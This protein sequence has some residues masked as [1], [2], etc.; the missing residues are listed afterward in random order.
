MP[1]D[2]TTILGKR[3]YR[4]RAAAGYGGERKAAEFARRLGITP[5]SLHDLESGKSRQLG[6][7]AW[8]GY[9]SVGANPHYII[10]GNGLPMLKNIEK[11]LRAQTLV[12]M[13]LELEDREI[14]TVEDIVKAYIRA[15]PGASPNDPFKEDPPPLDAGSE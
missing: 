15:K 10:H 11:N 7:K 3:L 2:Q 9:I 13:M 14:D 6:G 1:T 5:A 8:Q 4:V 12:S